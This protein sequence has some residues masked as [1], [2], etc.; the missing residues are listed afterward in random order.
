MEFEKDLGQ[1]QKSLDGIEFERYTRQKIEPLCEGDVRIWGRDRKRPRWLTKAVCLPM[2]N[3]VS[4]VSTPDC[5][6]ILYNESMMKV[7]AIIHCRS[8]L[9]EPEKPFFWVN[10]M[11]N[12]EPHKHILHF[13]FTKD[14]DLDLT[15]K[16]PTKPREMASF[17]DATYV[18]LPSNNYSAIFESPFLW[19]DGTAC[20]QILRTFPRFKT[21]VMSHLN[22]FGEFQPNF[23]NDLRER[24]VSTASTPVV[25]LQE[26]VPSGLLDATCLFGEDKENF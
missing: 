11:R 16:K 17:F 21:E 18:L 6:A 20:N 25:S 7:L 19:N 5:D 26:E 3:H 9:R 13:L 15:E 14:N 10:R 12:S 4:E 24:L 22:R 23:L 8:N 1:S 2:N